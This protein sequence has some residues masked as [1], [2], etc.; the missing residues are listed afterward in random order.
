[1]EFLLQ[2]IDWV[3]YIAL[4]LGVVAGLFVGNYYFLRDGVEKKADWLFGLLLCA[5]SFTLLHILMNH[6]GL[7]KLYPILQSLPIYYTLSLGPLLFHFVKIKLFPEY[8]LKWSD[9]K[10]LILPIGQGL[11]F[12]FFLFQP[13][14]FKL[15]FERNF[16]SPFYG[17]MEMIFYISTFFVYHYFAYRYIKAKRS[18]MKSTKNSRTVLKVAWLKRMVKA[19]FTL[20]FLN[21]GYILT[22]FFSYKLFNI[23]LHHFRGFNYLGSISFAAMLGWLTFNGWIMRRV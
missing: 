11:Y 13:I 1:M 23:D 10:H 3:I 19:L 22:D 7:F 16:F 18:Q 5:F 15:E 9:G 17:A 20:F 21:A 12:L 4:L 14:S 2:I 6:K 8:Q